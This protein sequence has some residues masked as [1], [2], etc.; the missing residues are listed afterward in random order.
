MLL[1]PLFPRPPVYLSY[2]GSVASYNGRHSSNG[3]LVQKAAHLAETMQ[4]LRELWLDLTSVATQPPLPDLSIF[5]GLRRLELRQPYSDKGLWDS[6]LCGGL[7]Q[8]LKELV[9]QG[10][11]MKL[12]GSTSLPRL[13]WLIFRGV[14]LEVDAPLPNLVGLQ[15]RFVE[16]ARLRGSGLQL[17]QLEALCLG[18]LDPGGSTGGQADVAFTELPSLTELVLHDV[19]LAPDTD[20]P[21]LRTLENLHI[22]YAGHN[23]PS[24]KLAARALTAAPRGLRSLQITVDGRPSLVEVSLVLLRENA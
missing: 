20:L 19:L 4:A 15:A 16:R 5:H 24:A 3:P 23:V 8:S 13:S 17:P 14:R 22:V 2:L 1:T 18:T 10:G 7:P 11:Q 12:A 9:F 21:Q 6:E